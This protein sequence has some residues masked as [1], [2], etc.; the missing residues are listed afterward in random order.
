M[1]DFAD[2]DFLVFPFVNNWRHAIQLQLKDTLTLGYRLHRLTPNEKLK[3]THNLSQLWEQT[4]AMVASTAAGA[5]SSAE[6]TVLTRIIGQLTTM[7]HD[8]QELRYHLRTNGTPTL[9]NHEYINLPTFHEVLQSVSAFVE[10]AATC[11][12]ESIEFEREIAEEF[13]E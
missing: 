3:R 11:L 5:V 6:L 12:H 2:R 1:N 13:S 10:A 7:D 9:P 8:G 4:K